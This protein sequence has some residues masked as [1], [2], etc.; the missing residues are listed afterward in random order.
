MSA[1]IPENMTR[2]VEINTTRDTIANISNVG[3][4][5]VRTTIRPTWPSARKNTSILLNTSDLVR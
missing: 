1:F 3:G 2:P 4:C 5:N